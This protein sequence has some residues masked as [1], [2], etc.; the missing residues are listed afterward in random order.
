[1]KFSYILVLFLM[2]ITTWAQDHAT[3]EVES[4]SYKGFEYLAVHLQ[5]EEHWHTYWK[6]PGDA[7]LATKFFFKKNDKIIA[8]E[9]LPWPSPKTISEGD[10]R[11][12]GYEGLA[13]FYFLVPEKLIGSELEIKAQYLICKEICLP[14]EKALKYKLKKSAPSTKFLEGFNDLPQKIKTVPKNIEL[15][16]VQKEGTELALHYIVNGIK[17]EDIPSDHNLLTPYLTEMFTY[18]HEIVGY[19]ENLNTLFGEIPIDWNGE[20]QEPPLD[21]PLDAIFKTPIPAKFLLRLQGEKGIIFNTTFKSF[22]KGGYETFHQQI[23][24]SNQDSVEVPGSE[25]SLFTMFL[26]ALIGGLILN[27]MPCVL[28]VI[29]LKLFGL[30]AHSDESKSKIMR[31]NLAYTFGVLSSFWIL[32]L[33][34]IFLKISGENI[35]WGFQ[36][37]SPQFVFLMLVLMFVMALNMLGLFE[38]IT[39]GGKTLGTK[40]LKKGFSGDFFNGVLATI[41][42]TP[43]SAPFLGA[44]LGFAFTTNHFNIFMI[45]TGVGLGLS[46]PF[47]LTAFIPSLIK[48]LPKP[49]S[50][51]EKLKMLLGL[52]LLLTAVWLYDVFA[53][54]VDLSFNGIYLNTFLVML[55]FAF[56]FRKHIS[57]IFAWN[58]IFFLI[59][60]FI[61]FQVFKMAFLMKNNI[62]VILKMPTPLLIGKHGMKT[63]L[64]PMKG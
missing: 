26:F 1:M 55:F 45:F 12:Y 9:S 32:A 29:S 57:K 41:L 6:N 33:T 53:A 36:M 52:S 15:S 21:L 34:V 2:S 43:C 27:F 60:A 51:M 4:A 31:H 35:G 44:A 13:S 48:L 14:G 25:Y 64:N 46:L 63:N 42:S 61:L 38:F 49:G 23:L 20:Y 37:Q 50:W 59:P 19:D 47:I 10:L 16:L 22:S 8:L 40:E 24:N 39:P 7:G 18:G 28:P 54:L 58:T 62:Q 3:I 5:H 11:A 56:F 17:K 30:V